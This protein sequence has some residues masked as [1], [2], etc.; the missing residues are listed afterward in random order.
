MPALTPSFVF[1]LERRMRVNREV[2][3]ARRLS[4]QNFWANRVLKPTPMEG[5]TERVTWLLETAT[6]ERTG[7]T[8]TGKLDF[9][10]LVSL[11]TELTSERHG[12]G[13]QIQRDQ[14]EDLD[15]TGLNEAVEWAAQMG[16]ESAYYQQRLASQALLNGAATDGSANAYDTVPFFADQTANTIGGVSV[17]G[18]PYNPFS[19]SLGGYANWLH[20]A[21]ATF[22]GVASFYP[23]ALPIDEASVTVDVALKNLGRAIAWAKVNKMP[24]GIDPRF[25]EID[26]IACPPIMIPRVRQLLDAK[27]IAQMAGALSTSNFGAGSA[28]ITALVSGWGL[29]K[30]LEIQEIQAGQSYNYDAP[31]VTAGGVPTSKNKTVTGSDST[32]Y[33]FM[34]QAQSTQLGS[35]LFMNRKP[36]KMTFYSGDAGSGSGQSGVSQVQ[37]DR[38]NYLEYHNQG[39]VSVQYGHPYGVYRF[40]AT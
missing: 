37:L 21:A 34:K 13:V 11:T 25:L 30:P 8:G 27:F 3:Y 20:G 23:G 4:A 26:Y 12:K 5:R 32:W 35:L 9:Q 24:N 6:I 40:D 36:F 31:Y 33:I 14:L 7:P 22:N 17:T 29:G 1:E 28:D 19:P 2:E 10:N 38:M 18:H 16:S 39:R 15:G